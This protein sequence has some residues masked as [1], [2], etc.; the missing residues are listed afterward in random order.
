MNRFTMIFVSIQRA[1]GSVV[2]EAEVRHKGL[3]LDE[4]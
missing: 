1:K 3:L 2:Y 4:N